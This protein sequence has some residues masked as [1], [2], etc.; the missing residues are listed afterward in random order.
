MAKYVRRTKFMC[1]PTEA[2]Y[3]DQNHWFIDAAFAVH[4]SGISHTG[5]YTTFG[6]GMIDGSTK[7]QQINTTSSTKA[8]VVGVY[9]NMPAIL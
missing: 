5:A 2:T 6:K 8:E 7:G 9:E 3:L 1:L 4:D